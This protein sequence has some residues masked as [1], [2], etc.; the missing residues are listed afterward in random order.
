MDHV[1]QLQEELESDCG[2]EKNNK[3]KIKR[4]GDPTGGGNPLEKKKLKRG[5][6]T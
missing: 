4:G 6:I 3:D 2:R 5:Y 1:H